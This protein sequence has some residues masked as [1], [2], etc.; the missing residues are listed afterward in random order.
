ME[1][2]F[3]SSLPLLFFCWFGL[4]SFVV[5]VVVCFARGMPHL[6]KGISSS[7][8]CPSLSIIVNC[9]QASSQFLSIKSPLS[10]CL[11]SSLS[12]LSLQSRVNYSYFPLSS[13]ILGLA[14][15]AQLPSHHPASLPL[16]LSPPSSHILT[17]QGLST[18]PSPGPAL[19]PLQALFPLM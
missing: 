14:L 3:Y 1:L 12:A 15:A 17:C 6:P 4:F 16:S 18:L 5:V 13:Q 19:H 2:L 7:T 8:P 10:L 9:L 11:L